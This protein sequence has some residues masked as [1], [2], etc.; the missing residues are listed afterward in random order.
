MGPD[1]RKIGIVGIAVVIGLAG[2]ESES[3]D[4]STTPPKPPPGPTALPEATT[5]ATTS[6][7][8]NDDGHGLADGR[9]LGT[10]VVGGTTFKVD[11]EGDVV[12][13]AKLPGM[14]DIVKGP[15]APVVRVWIGSEEGTKVIKAT[16]NAHGSHFHATVPVTFEP[17]ES[18]AF[19]L[20]VAKP[21]GTRATGSLP[22]NVVAAAPE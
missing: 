21:D 9:T 8:P 2:C 6:S 20:E 4:S 14:I 13:S 5:P 12:A 1:L 17:D 7:A 15:P 11:I 10:L 22:V 18:T 16:A 3:T 19:W